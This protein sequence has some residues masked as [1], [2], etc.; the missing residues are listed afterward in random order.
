MS[1]KVLALDIAIEKTGFC[2]VDGVVGTSKGGKL[3]ARFRRLYDDVY[4]LAG[5]ADLVIMEDLPLRAMS[6]ALTG[7]AH[8]VVRLALHDLGGRPIVSVVAS[9]LKKYATRNGKA[10]KE[11]M[12]NAYYTAIAIEGKSHLAKGGVTNDEA[13]AFHLWR[14]GT[15]WLR[16][17][18]RAREANVD[19][20]AWRNW[21]I[22]QLEVAGR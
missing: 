18:P 12:I 5:P 22:A 10:T 7:R 20:T 21:Q 11:D 16:H 6:A 19:F 4:R 1:P 15:G 17:E 9:T 2:T 8:G 3:D 13:D 14:L